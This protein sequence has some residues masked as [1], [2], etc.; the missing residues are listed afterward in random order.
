MVWDLAVDCIFGTSFI[1]HHV[2][3]IILELRNVVFYHLPSVA[4]TCQRSFA[5]P[6]ISLTFE[7]EDQ[8][9]KLRTTRKVTIP[10]V[11]QANLQARVPNSALCSVQNIQRLA[12]KHLTLVCI[13]EN[14]LLLSL[15]LVIR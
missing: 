14:E 3:A 12:T 6:E 5:K 1:D 9:R 15:S 10:P 4:I 8:S 11:S 13:S 7:S 2:K